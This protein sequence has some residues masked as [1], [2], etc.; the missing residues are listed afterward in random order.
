MSFESEFQSIHTRETPGKANARL[1]IN[2]P[3]LHRKQRRHFILHDVLPALFTV[4]ALLLIPVLRPGLPELAAFL[5]MWT[6]TGLGV[7]TGYHRLFAHKSWVA[8]RPLRNALAI[9]GAMAGQGSV[10]S[11]VAMHR[12]HHERS[13]ADG[14]MHSPNLHGDDWRGR[15]RGFLHAHLTWMMAH[16]YPSVVHYAP[17]LMRDRTIAWIHKHYQRW[18]IL[19]LV[20][21]ALFCALVERSWSGLLM[22]FL[23]GGMVRMFVLEHGIWSL[24]SLCHMM[25]TRRWAT[26]DKSRNIGLIAPFIFGESWHHNHHAFP[27]SAWFGLR[28]WRVDPGY[29]FIWLMGVLGLARDIKVPER[30]QLEMRRAAAR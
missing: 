28:W 1:T 29:W 30:A 12:R 9:T 23:W 22:G 3:F 4:V 26:R 6:V 18:V 8:A 2:D 15:L 5:V 25:G 11:W 16:P 24:N 19:G 21:P 17:D 20:L 27:G 13:D 10:L 7:S 14:D